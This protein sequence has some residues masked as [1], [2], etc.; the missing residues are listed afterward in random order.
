MKKIAACSILLL[1]VLLF[2]IGCDTPKKQEKPLEL[3]FDKQTAYFTSTTELSPIDGETPT[4]G[5]AV[6]RATVILTA[7]ESVRMRLVMTRTGEVKVS[8]LCVRVN[9][10]TVSEF[11]DTLVLYTS[12]NAEQRAEVTIELWLKANTPATEAG[13]TMAFELT[14]EYEG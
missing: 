2:A 6:E 3:S 10:N 4:S 12:A 8:G 13:K 5:D 11:E 14:L 9:G 7:S 1:F